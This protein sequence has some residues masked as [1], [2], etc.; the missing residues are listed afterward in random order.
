M[1]Q[2][3]SVSKDQSDV[4]GA[5][6]SIGS[7]KRLWVNTIVIQSHESVYKVQ[8]RSQGAVTN[9]DLVFVVYTIEY[10]V[11]SLFTK[12]NRDAK[13]KLLIWIVTSNIFRYTIKLKREESINQGQNRCQ[14]C[15]C[16]HWLCPTH[17]WTSEFV[18]WMLRSKTETGYAFANIDC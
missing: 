1:C 11:H 6:A 8:N 12:S 18:V 10:S 3:E 15:S 7:C 5:V 2:I 4:K 13:M 16:K 9:M 17:N 14:V